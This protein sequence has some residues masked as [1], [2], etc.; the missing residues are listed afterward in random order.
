MAKYPGAD[1]L[2]PS[3]TDPETLRKFMLATGSKPVLK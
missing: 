3:T 1:Q 2:D